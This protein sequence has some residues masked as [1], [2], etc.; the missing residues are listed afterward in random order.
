MRRYNTIT[1]LELEYVGNVI[2]DYAHSMDNAQSMMGSG[3]RQAYS[4]VARCVECGYLKRLDGYL[5]P[6]AKAFRECRSPFPFHQ[7]GRQNLKHWSTIVSVREYLRRDPR[8]LF[9]GWKHERI[10]R[11]E[12]GLPDAHEFMGPSSH[13]PDGVAYLTSVKTGAF[14]E[15]AIEVETSYKGPKRTDDMLMK[16]AAEYEHIWYFSPEGYVYDLIDTCIRRLPP[17]HFAKFAL[18]TLDTILDDQTAHRTP[19]RTQ[20]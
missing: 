3:R 11:Q 5:L 2:F 7:L 17:E 14:A 9:N 12:K 13:I 8:F 15:V 20:V 6:T 1:R 16:L 10:I 4:H 19:H 18:W